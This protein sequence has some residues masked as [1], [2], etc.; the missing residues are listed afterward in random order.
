MIR[1]TSADASS[2]GQLVAVNPVH[3]VAVYVEFEG[4]TRIS[5]T[6]GHML[7]VSE[8]FETVMSLLPSADRP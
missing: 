2:M 1:L 6:T 8:D 4:E 7:I 3:V 5:T